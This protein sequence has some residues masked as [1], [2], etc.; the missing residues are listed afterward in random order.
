MNKAIL[1]LTDNAQHKIA[2]LLDD[3]D[4]EVL[5]LRV[6]VVKG[7]CT[8]FSYVVEYATEIPPGA[9]VV[10]GDFGTL[11][12][13]PAA[14]L[15][16]LGAEMDYEDTTLHSRFVFSNPNESAKCGCGLSIAF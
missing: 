7:G 6:S 2:A 11:S 13:D 1:T 8:G 12:I 15:Y 5:A 3:A 4:A 10:H 14:V 9:E 16:L